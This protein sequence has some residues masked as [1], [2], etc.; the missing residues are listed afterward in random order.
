M[1]TTVSGIPRSMQYMPARSH[2]P[3][4]ECAHRYKLRCAL[5]RDLRGGLSPSSVNLV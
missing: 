4:S 1:I 2:W 3:V 5:T